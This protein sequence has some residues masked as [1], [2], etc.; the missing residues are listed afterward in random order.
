MF[1]EVLSPVDEIAQRWQQ[2]QLVEVT[3]TDLI[4]GGDGVGRYAQRAVF[5]PDTVTGDR[6]L[7]RLMRVKKQ[8]ALGQV[9]NLL[10]PSPHRIRPNCIVADRCGGCQWQHVDYDYQQVAKRQLVV[11]AL[12]RIGG[13]EA[14]PVQSLL[15]QE[16]PLG[17][18]NKAT[19]PLGRSGTGQVKAG[20][21]RKGS[22][23]LVNLNRCPVQDEQLDPMLAELKQDIQDRGWSIYDE[24]KHQGKLRHLSLRIGRRTGQ[25]L[26]TLVSTQRELLGLEAQAQVW[27]DRYPDLM[28]VCIN[29]NP[30]K[31]NAIFGPRTHCI[32]G[33]P[34]LE[35]VFGGLCF[36]IRPE[37]F[38][39]VHTEQAEALL[40][41]ISQRLQLQ[42]DELLLDA[43]SGVGTLSLP[44]AQKVGRVIAIEAQAQAVE[45]ARH[46]ALANGITNVEFHSGTVETVLPALAD[47][48]DVVLLDPPR[49]GCDRRVINSLLAQRPRQIVYM[50][51]KMAT[52]ARD[53]KLLCEGEQYRLTLV[54]PA[55]FFPQTSHVEAAAFLERVE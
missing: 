40:R 5:V 26:L 32:S 25:V 4:D 36:Q 54:Q 49:K 51:C 11:D 15:P 44:L 46:N 10:Q 42:G 52:L 20:Y 53:L 41:V 48:P 3:I 31:T 16:S 21:Y 34:Y 39:Q 47:L 38:F 13:F 18:R 55:D 50:S 24:E 37:T 35:E 45:Q 6:A 7:V 30:E 43:Y 19:Y 9:V 22:H 17:Y 8:Y 2:G 28:G 27:H 33:Q 29:E 1:S 12:T 23:R 14:P